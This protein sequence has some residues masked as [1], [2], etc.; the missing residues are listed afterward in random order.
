MASV[1][2]EP[3][4]HK[5]IEWVKANGRRARVRLGKM[6]KRQALE[7]NTCIE[8]LIVA[9][10]TGRMDASTAERV[11]QLDDTLHGRIART[12]LVRPRESHLLGGWVDT[13]ITAKTND[14][15]P[16]S[17]RKLKAT[18]AKL[19]AHFGEDTPLRAVSAADTSEWRVELGKSL[20]VA[21]AKTHVGNAK[22]I[23]AEAVRREILH[24][25]PFDHL[26]G[27]VT[28]TQNDRYVTPE[29]IARVI[30]EAPGTEWKLLIG[31]A[32]YAGL[33]TPSETSLLTWADVDFDQ[34]RLRVRSP[35]T[36]RHAGHEQR[37]VPV[38]ARLLRLLQARFDAAEEGEEQLIT[39]KGA[40]SRRRKMVA[41]IERAGVEPW[42]DMWQTLRRSC[43]IEW[44]QTF[45]QYAV[46]RW[47]GH[48]ISVSGK[49]YANAIPDELFER[50]GNHEAQNAAQNTAEQPRTGKHRA[51]NGDECNSRKHRA[52]TDLRSGAHECASANNGAGGNRTPVP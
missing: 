29:Q 2:S 48:S 45:P 24:K 27:G 49:H 18:G 10:R 9:Q 37:T 26:K 15:K 30:D 20:S 16:E 41:I 19:K 42:R 17:L 25:S 1:I 40:G 39:I 22:T 23:F 44:A 36:E 43:E 47:I 51:N 8:S 7:I 46:S 21:S 50:V 12:G 33:R 32:R 31:L 52:Y 14:L 13:V 28:A 34:S 38:C 35:K 3:N 11:S 6:H 5:R 4:G